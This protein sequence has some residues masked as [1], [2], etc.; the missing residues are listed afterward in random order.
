MN[1]YGTDFNKERK[2]ENAKSEEEAINILASQSDEYK[3]DLM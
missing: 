2:C 3:K 1:K